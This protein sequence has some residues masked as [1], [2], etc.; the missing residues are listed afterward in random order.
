MLLGLASE[1]VGARSEGEEQERRRG[2]EGGRTL[3][4]R[5][6][7]VLLSAAPPRNSGSCRT[8]MSLPLI[9]H[10]S[11]PLHPSFPP[12]VADLDLDHVYFALH[13]F[14]FLLPLRNP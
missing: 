11:P 10:L 13:C 1:E 8:P 5:Q 7:L 9:A 3:W 6:V 4:R 2:R 14:R 12:S